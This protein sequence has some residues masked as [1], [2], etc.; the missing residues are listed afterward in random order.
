MW[1]FKTQ[2]EK[3]AETQRRTTRAQRILKDGE[4]IQ[5]MYPSGFRTEFLDYPVFI[6]SKDMKYDAV[7]WIKSHEEELEFI[8]DVAWM[9]ENGDLQKQKICGD[10]E[11]LKRMIKPKKEVYGRYPD[12]VI[13]EDEGGAPV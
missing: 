5:K 1:P 7:W 11:Y 8:I 4:E 13:E 9:N 3:E 10:L 6:F 12:E 2:A